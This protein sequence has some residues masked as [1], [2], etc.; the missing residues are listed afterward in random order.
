MGRVDALC[1]IEEETLIE[2]AGRAVAQEI[3]R[4]HGV[5]KTVLLCGES[6]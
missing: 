5:R 1:G 4:R 6:G 3:A 2:N